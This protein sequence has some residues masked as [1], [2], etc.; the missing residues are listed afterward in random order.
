[1]NSAETADIA[2][3]AK[4]IYEGR[5]K[6]SMESGYKDHFLAIEPDSGHHF[7]GTTL[8]EAADAARA[9]HPDKIS[10]VMRIGH[11]A[12]FQ[13]GYFELLGRPPID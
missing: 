7:L 4:A 5:L 12:L 8:R 6:A 11:A 10:F 3:R 9:R 2:R 13:T 1:M